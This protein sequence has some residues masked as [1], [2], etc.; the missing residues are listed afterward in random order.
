MSLSVR[1]LR[2][3]QGVRWRSF[4]DGVVVCVGETCETHLLPSDYASLLTSLSMAVDP[5]TVNN[6]ETTGPVI[7]RCPASVAVPDAVLQE[8]VDRKILDTDN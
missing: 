2:I 8:L 6:G 4:A 7:A 1:G 5:D 3:A